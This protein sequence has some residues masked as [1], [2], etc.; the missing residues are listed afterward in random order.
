MNSI[1]IPGRR[2]LIVIIKFIITLDV[3][4]LNKSFSSFSKWD[5]INTNPEDRQTDKPL[6]I[7][8][9]A[10]AFLKGAKHQGCRESMHVSSCR[11]SCFYGGR[12]KERRERPSV[13]TREMTS[14]S[15]I[16]ERNII[17]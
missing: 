17:P 14:P 5:D 9:L 4:H 1:L 2:V 15:G 11:R 13:T 3:R 6:E 7:A 10:N 16:R 8:F 12:G